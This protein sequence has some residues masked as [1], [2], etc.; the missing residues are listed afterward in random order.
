[1]AGSRAT[2]FVTLLAV[3]WASL[4]VWLGVSLLGRLASFGGDQEYA[5]LSSVLGLG[6][7]FLAGASW[8]AVFHHKKGVFVW[9]VVVTIG[10][11]QLLLLVM[12]VLI[13]LPVL[14]AALGAQTDVTR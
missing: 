3:S 5:R 9:P 13:A 14:G 2:T 1:M 7:P 11:W 12:L 6:L 8:S 10:V 4:A